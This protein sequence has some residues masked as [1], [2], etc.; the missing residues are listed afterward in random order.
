MLFLS[1]YNSVFFSS[2]FLPD[3]SFGLIWM[4]SD[5]TLLLLSMVDGRLLRIC[6]CD[7]IVQSAS[8]PGNINTPCVRT[9]C[10]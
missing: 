7:T 1:Q 10:Y 8:P 3:I 4:E 2:I 9:C 5:F 6:L